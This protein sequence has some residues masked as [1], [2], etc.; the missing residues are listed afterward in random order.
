MAT[1]Y[2]ISEKYLTHYTYGKIRYVYTDGCI[3]YCATDLCKLLN[4]KTVSRAVRKHCLQTGIKRCKGLDVKGRP[5]T[6][7]FISAEN[8]RILITHSDYSYEEKKSIKEWLFDSEILDND[9]Q[10]NDTISHSMPAPNKSEQSVNTCTDIDNDNNN[11]QTDD[12]QILDTE[13]IINNSE[14]YAQSNNNDVTIGSQIN[15]QDSINN[16]NNIN[17]NNNIA[18]VVTYTDEKFGTIRTISENGKVLFCAIDIA[19]SLGYQNVS[20]AI[21][22]HCIRDGITKRYIIDTISRYQETLFITEGNV[23]RLICHSKLPSATEFEKWVFDN[24]LPS[25][26]QTG[27]YMTNQAAEKILQNPDF[28]IQ[29]AQQ[30]KNAQEQVRLEQEKNIILSEKNEQLSETVNE[31]S[32]HIE[33]LKPKAEFCDDVLNSEGLLTITIIAKDYGMSGVAL[34]KYL[35]RK[36]VQYKQGDVWILYSKYQDKGYAQ[37]KTFTVPDNKG[38]KHSRCNLYWT[39][40]GRMFIHELLRKD[41]I[42]SVTEKTTNEKASATDDMNFEQLKL[43]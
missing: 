43:F 16:Q 39:E 11:T 7:I 17:Q 1:N 24:I 36:G 41:N 35:Y 13:L 12:K 38:N 29:L 6:F 14:S 30:V 20:K 5:N 15:N 27:L 32:T 26:K 34:N 3:M 28:I 19:K 25:I 40:K 42:L 9:C 8:A 4:Y 23:Y 10:I 33:Q 2:G 22:D 37:T 31:Q 21:S 18:D